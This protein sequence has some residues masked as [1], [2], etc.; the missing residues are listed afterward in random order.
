MP[1]PCQKEF[2]GALGLG[3]SRDSSCEMAPA[4]PPATAFL[5]ADMVR[6]LMAMNNHPQGAVWRST[7]A[8][9]GDPDGSLRHRLL[10]S[11]RRGQC[12]PKRAP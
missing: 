4:C 9:S 12:P 5:P 2:L 3:N 8:I 10:D 1:W 7:L 6:F 11:R